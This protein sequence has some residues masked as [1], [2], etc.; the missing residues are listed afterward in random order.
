M[1]PLQTH[2]FD[3]SMYAVNLTILKQKTKFN[4]AKMLKELNTVEWKRRSLKQ[5][6]SRYASPQCEIVRWCF[7]FVSLQLAV[8]ANGAF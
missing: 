8:I 6:T 2:K 4:Q 1:K 7:Y 5:N 3:R